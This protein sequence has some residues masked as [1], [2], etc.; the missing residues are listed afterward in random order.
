MPADYVDYADH[1]GWKYTTNHPFT[2]VI[3]DRIT[4][5]H[6]HFQSLLFFCRQSTDKMTVSTHKMTVK[7][8]VYP[9]M[10]KWANEKMSKR[11]QIMSHFVLV[12]YRK[13]S[14]WNVER[15]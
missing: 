11:D 12:D 9:A 6:Q 7:I 4:K 8:S 3:G 13:T 2:Y 1:A 10:K 15:K 14:P 5:K